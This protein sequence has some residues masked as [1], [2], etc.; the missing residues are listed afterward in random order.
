MLHA[1]QEAVYKKSGYG[2]L[3]AG[4]TTTAG[5]RHGVLKSWCGEGPAG[6]PVPPGESPR[7]LAHPVAETPAHNVVLLQIDPIFAKKKCGLAGG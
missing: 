5:C 3:T 7:N 6:W 1:R 2:L 4:E